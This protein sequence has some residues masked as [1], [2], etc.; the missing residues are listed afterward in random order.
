MT[1]VT[2]VG[3]Q[4]RFTDALKD[5]L[6]LE[7]DATETYTAA[8]DRLNDENY[9]AK[10]NEF[11][12]DHERHIEEIRKLLKASGEEFTDGPCGKQV[13]MIGKVAIANLIG[14]NSILKAMLAAEEDT[15][16]AYER[17]L[18]HEDKPSSADEFVRRAREDERRH[19]QWL[20]ETTA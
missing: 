9:K 8:V 15:N 2:L 11:K 18:N 19:K 1:M 3:T 10:L 12:A 5:L 16:T 14:D 6:E 4:A 20:E 13:L 17:M 7:Y